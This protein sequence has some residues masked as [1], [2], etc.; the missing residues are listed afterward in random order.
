METELSCVKHLQGCL[1]CGSALQGVT[2]TTMMAMLRQGWAWCFSL[3]AASAGQPVLPSPLPTPG[4]L[5]RPHWYLLTSH[6]ALL[7][8]VR[9]GR[10]GP[11]E[12]SQ[13]PPNKASFQEFPLGTSRCPHP[14]QPASC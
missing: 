2:V 1:A 10:G 9:A 5:H 7:M 8:S 6:R 12:G 11:L 3:P 13:H 4:S 14:T